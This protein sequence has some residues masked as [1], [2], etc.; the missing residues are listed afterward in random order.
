[1]ATTKDIAASSCSDATSVKLN[2]LFMSFGSRGDLQPHLEIA[3]VL[4]RRHGH[5]VRL[6]CPAKYRRQVE[7]EGVEF[8]CYG[9]ADPGEMIRR[10]LLP[11]AEMRALMPTIRAEFAQMA[12]RYWKACVGDPE[13][14]PDDG[15]DAAADREPFLA[16][17]VIASMQ[18]AVHSWM[19]ARMGV[20][21]HMIGTNPRSPSRYLPHSQDAGA[22]AGDSVVKNKLSW[23][24]RDFM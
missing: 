10:R 20:P 2:V 4:Q 13:G 5:R 9:D 19:A 23:L 7:A 6:V 8:Y 15:P 3:K 11:R 18:M 17:V 22:A 1:M 16:D 14:L 24:L 21:L 12:E